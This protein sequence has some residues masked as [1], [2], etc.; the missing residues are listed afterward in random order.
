MMKISPINTPEMIKIPRI[1]LKTEMI[2]IPL[3]D[4]MMKIQPIPLKDK[5]IKIPLK[6]EMKSRR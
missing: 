2:K 4:E 6:E 3:K 1:N 5:M